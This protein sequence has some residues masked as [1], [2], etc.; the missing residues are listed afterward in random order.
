MTQIIR[1]NTYL[2]TALSFFYSENT[3]RV[4]LVFQLTVV[5]EILTIGRPNR[6]WGPCE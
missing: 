4:L 5:G 3:L 1:L 6:R 2:R